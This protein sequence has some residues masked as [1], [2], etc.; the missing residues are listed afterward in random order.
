MKMNNVSNKTALARVKAVTNRMAWAQVKAV[1]Q[2]AGNDQECSWEQA[3]D[4][5]AN[6]LSDFPATVVGALG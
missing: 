4:A 3:A 1:V 6:R 5:F 2:I